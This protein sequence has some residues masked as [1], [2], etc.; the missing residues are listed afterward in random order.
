[1]DKVSIIIISYNHEEYI[2]KTSITCKYQKEK[3]VFVD[4][5]MRLWPC[6][7][8]GAP[9]YFGPN[10]PQRKSFENFYKLYGEDFNNMRKYGWEVLNHEFFTTYLDKSWNDQDEKF[11]RIYT[12]GRTCGNKFEFSSGYGKNTKRETIN[13]N[14]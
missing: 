13:E 4:M 9:L 12:C 5:E 7:W 8:M 6:T 1:M 11:K 2:E 14:K 3:S 10:N